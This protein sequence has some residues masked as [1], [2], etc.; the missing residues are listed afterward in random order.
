MKLPLMFARRYL[1]SKKQHSSINIMSMISLIGVAVGTMALVVI[2]SVYNG[3]DSYIKSM[4]SSFDPEIKITAKTGKFFSYDDSLKNVL[5]KLEGINSISRV[6]EENALAKYAD[7][8]QIVVVKGVDNNYNKVVGLDSMLAVGQF[9]LTL[10]DINYASTGIQ[11]AQTMGIGINF[12]DPLYIY[13]PNRDAEDAS[14]P[15]A[16]VQTYVFPNS[17]FCTNLE[18]DLKYVIVP[19]RLIDTAYSFTNGQSTA[20]EI[21]LQPTANR[22]LV[23]KQLS[24]SLDDRFEVKDRFM[25]NE[26]LF[27]IMKSEKWIIYL[28]LS[29]ILVVASFN[30]IGSLSM[31]MLDKQEDVFVL[32]SMGASK[33]LISRIFLLEGWMIS[34]IGAFLGVLLGL[35]IAIAQQHFK[36][37]K[38]YTDGA[39]VLDAYPVEV[40]I[41]DLFYV[42]GI[43]VLI[44]FFAARYPIAA[45]QRQIN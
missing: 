8:Q 9:K 17:A 11:V 15:D 1:F 6:I 30:I 25:Q 41:P 2:L 43:V 44:G 13:F 7:K 22:E 31:L 35:G 28:I 23:Y 14:S 16:F 5:T 10:G 39:F 18:Y 24:K 3:F 21:K 42:F 19:I 27:R 32:R 34:I 40:Q 26:V 45:L 36:I 4:Y 29:L 12:M 37:V 20:L 38:L 33:R